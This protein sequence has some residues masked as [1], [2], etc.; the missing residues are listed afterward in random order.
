MKQLRSQRE[1]LATS[2]IKQSDR[3]PPDQQL[4]HQLQPRFISSWDQARL[5]FVWYVAATHQAKNYCKRNI[6]LYCRVDAIACQSYD[7]TKKQTWYYRRPCDVHG[8]VAIGCTAVMWSTEHAADP[9]PCDSHPH[10]LLNPAVQIYQ[11]RR[12]S[13]PSQSRL[14]SPAQ[15]ISGQPEITKLNITLH[16]IKVNEG[17]PSP[18]TQLY[19]KIYRLSYQNVFS[20]YALIH[21]Y[22]TERRKDVNNPELET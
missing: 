9:L 19:I 17:N 2:N 14:H 15:H 6:I 8:T 22:M 16:D 4:F 12:G 7:S 1:K 3:S 21:V 20:V 11:A 5:M 13:F 10:H 18:L